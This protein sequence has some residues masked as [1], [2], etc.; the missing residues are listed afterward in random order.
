MEE[1]WH[2]VEGQVALRWLVYQVGGLR[3]NV[4]AD[5]LGVKTS[6]LNRWMKKG[7]PDRGQAK[8]KISRLL[9]QNPMP[10]DIGICSMEELLGEVGRRLDRLTADIRDARSRQ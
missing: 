4:L 3:Q 2:P 9:K 8:E 1:N 7:I 6:A 5:A 10:R